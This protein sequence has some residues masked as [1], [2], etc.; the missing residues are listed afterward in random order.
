MACTAY[1]KY[2]WLVQYVAAYHPEPVAPPRTNGASLKPD[3]APDC[4][5]E[6]NFITSRVCQQQTI[7]DR[8]VLRS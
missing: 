6:V 5:A 3:L 8:Q 7:L 1:K 4:T 2:F